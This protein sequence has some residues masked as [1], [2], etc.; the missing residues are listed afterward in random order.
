MTSKQHSRTVVPFLIDFLMSE[1]CCSSAAFTFEA[2]T[3]KA[4]SLVSISVKTF[5]MSMSTVTF[6]ICMGSLGFEW[7]SSCGACGGESGD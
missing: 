2:Q 1:S 4:P 5:P 7:G 6:F 3:F